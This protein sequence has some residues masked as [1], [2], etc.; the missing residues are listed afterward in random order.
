MGHVL[1][2]ETVTELIYKHRYSSLRGNL[3]TYLELKRDVWIL[4]DNIDKA[5]SPHGIDPLDLLNLKCLLDAFTKLRNDLARRQITL[6][7]VVFVR[8]DVYELLVESTPDRG[9]IA[10]ATLDWTDSE[11]LREL[12]RRRFV[13]NLPIKDL[14]FDVIWRSVAATHICGGQET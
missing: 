7:G 3:V 1:S 6:H 14:E 13:S 11:L 2:R 10:K 8:N 12:L 4:F 9:K 5:W